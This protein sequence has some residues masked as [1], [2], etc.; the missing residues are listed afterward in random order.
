LNKKPLLSAANFGTNF[1]FIGVVVTQ[2]THCVNFG[3]LFISH[4][5]NN[6][7]KIAI[8]GPLAGNV[9]GTNDEGLWTN[10]SGSLTLV[11]RKGSQAAGAPTGVNYGTFT[12][13][14]WPVL[15]D[16]GQVA[17][18]TELAGTSVNSSNDEGIWL[19]KPDA[20]ALMARRGDPAPGTSNGVRFG[21]LDYPTL[22][23]AGQIAFRA[24]L[25]GSGIGS[26]NDRGIWATDLTGILQLIA[27]VGDQL[28]VTPGDFRMLRDI[29]F[30]SAS[31][32]SDG[33]PSGFNN[34]G[35][36]AFWASFTDGSQGVFVSNAVAY[37]PGDFNRDG[38][39]TGDD[40]KSMLVALTDLHAF[41]GST[42]LSEQ[43]LALLGDLN[44]DHAVTNA[45]IQ[46]LLNLLAGRGNG[47]AVPEPAGI[48]LAVC[49]FVGFVVL[50]RCCSGTR[51]WVAVRFPSAIQNCRVRGQYKGVHDRRFEDLDSD[52]I[53]RSNCCQ[54]ARAVTE[55]CGGYWPVGRT[56]ASNGCRNFC[57][58]YLGRLYFGVVERA[59]RMGS[60][61][62][63]LKGAAD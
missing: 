57:L 1:N 61:R 18:I 60:N 58:C 53:G 38:K 47:T 11:A 62:L 34:I 22:N 19:G 46:P 36:L 9:D 45:D 63:S 37:V 40:V 5:F 20:L 55:S 14:G 3:N 15:N 10:V 31:G 43:A 26:S 8:E 23:S 33:R 16:A 28:E 4:G 49:G 17:F 25:N 27:R 35:Q 51:L 24:A 30:S 56:R 48:M 42:G 12:H 29:N 39:L 50:I 6:A 13:S 41:E 2:N 44:G 59:K 54:A 7:G 52:R 21:D 32:N